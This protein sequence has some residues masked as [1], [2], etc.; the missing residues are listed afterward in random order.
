[1]TR[2]CRCFIEYVFIAALIML[3]CEWL[4]PSGILHTCIK[5]YV[6][7][8]KLQL[9]ASCC[10]ITEEFQAQITILQTLRPPESLHKFIHT[11]ITCAYTVRP[12]IHMTVRHLNE[13]WSSPIIRDLSA[14]SRWITQQSWQCKMSRILVAFPILS[15]QIDFR[16]VVNVVQAW[17]SQ[18]GLAVELPLTVA[19]QHA[20]KN[21]IRAL[22]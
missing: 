9:H 18:W 22:R 2:A 15:S 13:H 16:A 19:G 21:Y 8:P 12:L 5:L 14:L 3:I 7:R 1:M 4:Y 20:S 6:W 11:G 10:T 17:S